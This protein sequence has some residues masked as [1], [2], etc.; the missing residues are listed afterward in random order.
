MSSVRM[1]FEER[2]KTLIC[3]WCN[4]TL[5][6]QL[7]GTTS[8][9][10]RHLQ[11]KHPNV[12]L[13][14]TETKKAVKR[15]LESEESPKNKQASL[16]K[17]MG[18]STNTSAKE[19]YDAAV[20]RYILTDGRPLESV[21]S[22]GFK[23]LCLELTN[24]CYCPPH[25]S[26]LSRQLHNLSNSLQESL[27]ESLRLEVADSRPSITF[28]FWKTDNQSSYLVIGVH[29]IHEL[30]WMMQTRCLSVVYLDNS[31]TDSSSV[32][33]EE[34]IRNEMEK[35]GIEIET[36][37]FATTDVTDTGPLTTTSLGIQWQGCAAHILQLSI[38]A[39][40]DAQKEVKRLII[41]AYHIASFISLSTFSQTILTKC[42]VG[43]GLCESRPPFDE[44]SSFSSIY[45]I[46]EW[47]EKNHIPISLTLTEYSDLKCGKNPP[48]PLTDLQRDILKS[49]LPL[50]RPTTEALLFLGVDAAV[51]SSLIIPCIS[52]LKEEL[53]AVSS[54][55]VQLFCD[56]LLHQLSIRFDLSKG[57]LLAS[58]FVDPRFKL[59]LFT[60]DQ[61]KQAV[62]YIEKLVSAS[63][64]KMEEDS[65]LQ[66]D[67]KPDIGSI[68]S[69]SKIQKESLLDSLFRKV[70]AAQQENTNC[71]RGPSV[72]EKIQ[73][74]VNVYSKQPALSRDGDPLLYWKE[75]CKIF[76]MLAKAARDLLA[77]QAMNCSSER[78][79]S[80]GRHQLIETCLNLS[81]HDVETLIWSC[82]NKDLLI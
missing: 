71:N 42:Q 73:S 23:N 18:K 38:S 55:S 16:S 22:L 2:D 79:S 57:H 11:R 77:V 68:Q 80:S 82:K 53:A 69:E 9:L 46:L 4:N 78:I 35:H 1:H 56:E 24:G 27:M 19:R 32:T 26:T 33:D 30:T 65:Q 76:P 81:S 43:Q 39:A 31:D 63:E 60:E 59:F 52:I 36:I 12:Y 10:W 15:L 25:P 44:I 7:S 62:E 48:N 49:V 14:T 5:S 58:T 29:Y 54:S 70:H 21:A 64:C 51:S 61:A 40:L 37:F 34:I 74:E 50:L 66:P 17:P 67:V 8:H 41:Q 13:K 20:L 45:N 28:D 75:N 3:K 6:L 72:A 47:V